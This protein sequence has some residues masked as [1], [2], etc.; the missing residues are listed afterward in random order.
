MDM[1]LK[2]KIIDVL[3]KT[4]DL[5]IAT[6]R[7]DGYPQ[8]TVVSYVSDGLTIYFSCGEQSQKAR[9]LAR[10]NKVS[11]TVTRDYKSWD[12]ILGVSMAATAD[13]VTGPD[14]IAHVGKLM[15][16]KFPE[17]AKYISAGIGG[18]VLYR[19]TPKI[20]SLLDYNKE[21]GHTDLVAMEQGG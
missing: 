2:S 17:A 16:A 4:K 19:V 18:M 9:N 21:F 20:I 6:M 1:T 7:E 13:P 11:I 10:S 5:T 14:E 3:A 12:E 8:A 15:I